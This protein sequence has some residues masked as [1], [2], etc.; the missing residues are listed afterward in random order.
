MIQ[1]DLDYDQ[2]MLSLRQ[3]VKFKRYI[4]TGN[5]GH[6]NQTQCYLALTKY[7][8]SLWDNLIDCGVELVK[9]PG[10][11]QT[12]GPVEVLVEKLGVVD[13]AYFITKG[14]D[15]EEI[16]YDP[17][18]GDKMA[19]CGD[20]AS[21]DCLGN[22]RE[23][24]TY[25]LD[26]TNDHKLIKN[27][28]TNAKKDFGYF[29]PNP[30]HMNYICDYMEGFHQEF[31]QILLNNKHHLGIR[32]RL[33]YYDYIKKEE[34][35]EASMFL[36]DFLDIFRGADSLLDFDLS[37]L[38]FCEKESFRYALCKYDFMRFLSTL[39]GNSEYK[40]VQD[41]NLEQDKI[42][43]FKYFTEVKPL[44]IKLYNQEKCLELKKALEPFVLFME[45]NG[46]KDSFEDGTNSWW[47]FFDVK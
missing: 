29:K 8:F 30:D 11:S 31:K 22:H 35:H 18:F 3:W 46:F 13:L 15:P 27:L 4:L 14:I 24:L 38:W 40:S 5:S 32:R 43:A 39:W 44:V 34:V 26:N 9:E 37:S 19:K 6:M 7:R 2:F 21:T 42:E 33:S 47:P 36:G 16:G 20:Y 10:L 12:R 45:T 1:P 41:I 28:L 17:E 25:I 23:Y